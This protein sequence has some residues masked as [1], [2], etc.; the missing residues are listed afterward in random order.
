LRAIRR[1]FAFALSFAGILVFPQATTPAVPPDPIVLA[2]GDIADCNSSADSATAALLDAHPEGLVLT[3]GDNAY[4]NGTAHEFAECYDPTWGRHK[5]RTFPAP[6]NHEYNTPNAAGYF[7]YFGSAAGPEHRGYYSFDL[8]SW[9]VVSLNS[10][11]DTGLSGAQVA[12]LRADLAA[13]NSACVLAYWHT[14][15]WTGGR[16]S[17]QAAVQHFWNVLYDAGADI[18]LAGHDHNYQRYPPLDKAGAPDN[19]RGMRSFVVGTGGRHLYPLRADSR[20]EI[21]DDR[22][23]GVLELTLHPGA[24]SWRFLGVAGSTYS[25]SGSGAC[26]RANAPPS[27]PSSPT[28]PPSSPPP[29]PTPPPSP[30]SSIP[31][32]PASPAPP[33]PA[34]TSSPQPA[35][36]SPAE[37]SADAAPRSRPTATAPL[38]PQPGPPRIGRGPVL[39]SASGRGRI[40]LACPRPGPRCAGRLTVRRKRVD[41]SVAV[42]TFMVPPGSARPVHIDLSTKGLRILTRSGRLRGLVVALPAAERPAASRS[43]KLVLVKTKQR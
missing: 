26:S 33:A 30:P 1:L 15:R 12:W 13:T 10:E 39:V 42:G 7:A 32:S 23:F 5:S 22:T 20:R 18:V 38:K 8:G 40:W 29:P 9:H 34:P 19:A 25:D 35:P 24:Y 41:T 3:L 11:R 27:S 28:P 14:P 17:D 37:D 16:Y 6:G 4:E 21:G 31:A 36:S 43:V 2:A